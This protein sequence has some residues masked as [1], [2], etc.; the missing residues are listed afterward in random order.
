MPS[1]SPDS[2]AVGEGQG[3]GAFRHSL[4]KA[5]ERSRYY[6]AAS[7]ASRSQTGRKLRR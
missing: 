1:F 3:E 4:R 5:I 7:S 2:P 6:P